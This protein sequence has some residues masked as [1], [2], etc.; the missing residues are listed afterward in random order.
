MHSVTDVI[1]ELRG[2]GITQEQL[3]DIS[4]ELTEFTISR[5]KLY[6]RL[7]HF[8]DDEE[9]NQIL[10]TVQTAS[11]QDEFMAKVFALLSPREKQCYLMHTVESKSFGNIAKEL[12]VSKGRVQEAI[13]RSREK[14]ER[15]KKEIIKI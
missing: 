1:D 14:I 9:L 3:F 11:F 7:N 6:S 2:S 12:G 5:K 10:L 8:I 15:I 13:A 4:K